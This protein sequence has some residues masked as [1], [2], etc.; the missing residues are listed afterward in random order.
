LRC[1]GAVIFLLGLVSGDACIVVLLSDHQ[2]FETSF[3]AQ[4]D[5]APLSS[6]D[7]CGT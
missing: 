2:R 6:F 3:Q 4:E 1:A 7:E 5:K